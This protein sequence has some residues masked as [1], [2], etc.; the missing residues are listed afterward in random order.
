M[1]HTDTDI[2][3]KIEDFLSLASENT[4]KASNDTG[5]HGSRVKSHAD[6][7]YAI[8]EV[9]VSIFNQGL[10]G[11]E[12]LSFYLKEHAGMRFCA[13]A[14]LLKRD[15]RT[16]WDSYTEGRKKVTSFLPSQNS[17]FIPLSIFQNRTFGVLEA[18]SL[19]L[20]E[21]RC[22]KF[23]QIATLLGKNDRTIWTA[24]HRAKKK[25]TQVNHAG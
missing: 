23:S 12:A 14:S 5:T 21:D 2:P 1:A 3:S 4:Y 7:R 25:R 10:S 8:D 24:Y 17:L 16:I 9:P 18:L 11:L 19:H 20:K 22:L 6:D 13:I 15:D